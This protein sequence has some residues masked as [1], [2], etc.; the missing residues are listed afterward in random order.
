MIPLVR[1]LV[2]FLNC[3][4]QCPKTI[5][6]SQFEITNSFKQQV[7][8][9]GTK[10]YMIKKKYKTFINRI[11]PLNLHLKAYYATYERDCFCSTTKCMLLKIECFIK[12][13]LTFVV[14]SG[15]I[16][17]SCWIMILTINAYHMSLKI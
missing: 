15:A 13:K 4:L 1:Y 2:G 10:T 6:N 17:K 5:R 14:I 7:T 12:R 9:I 3:V 16:V 11:E 8:C